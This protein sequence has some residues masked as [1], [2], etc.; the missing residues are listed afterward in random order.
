[1]NEETTKPKI[2]LKRHQRF[3]RQV[4]W[5]LIRKIVIVAVLGG[6]VYYLMENIPSKQKQAQG[7]SE[8]EVLID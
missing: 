5:A 4:P 2:N 6:L 8:I 3:Q 7:A 1:M